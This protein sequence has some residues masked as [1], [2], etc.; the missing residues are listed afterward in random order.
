MKLHLLF[1]LTSHPFTFQRKRSSKALLATY[2]L[3]TDRQEGSVMVSKQRRCCDVFNGQVNL[4]H[5]CTFPLYHLIVFNLI[6]ADLPEPL[7]E[8][9]FDYEL[10]S[11]ENVSWIYTRRLRISESFR[12]NNDFVEWKLTIGTSVCLK[13][14]KV[15]FP[16]EI[17]DHR[18]AASE[19]SP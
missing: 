18:A 12:P 9:S 19:A 15:F 2:L 6:K 11:T 7:P 17:S 8:P 4:N 10:I 16:K 5:K 14:L 1:L 13:P 3:M